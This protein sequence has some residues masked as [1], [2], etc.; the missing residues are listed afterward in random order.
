M[1]K[2]DSVVTVLYWNDSSS[3]SVNSGWQKGEVGMEARKAAAGDIE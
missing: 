1:E 3:N 2:G